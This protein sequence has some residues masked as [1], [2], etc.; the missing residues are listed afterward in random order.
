MCIFSFQKGLATFIYK[1]IFLIGFLFGLLS[2]AAEV[3][4]ETELDKIIMAVAKVSDEKVQT[5]LLRGVIA[6]LKGVSDIPPPKGWSELSSKLLK[7]KNSEL[8]E[9]TQT[10]N[11]FFGSADALKDALALILN[12]KA[13]FQKRQTTLKSLAAKNYS[14]L[15]PKL[16]VLLK[17]KLQKDAI[18]SYGFYRSSNIPK[19][20][21]RHYKKFDTQSRQAVIETLATR[22]EFASEIVS[23]LKAKKISKKE[24]PAYIARNL[25]SLLGQKFISVYGEVQKVSNDKS[26]LIAS[27]KKKLNSKAFN[28]ASAARGRL[29]YDKQCAICHKMYNTGGIIGPDL[30]GSNRADQDYILLNIIDPNF[31]VPEAYQMTTITKKDG[32]IFSGN[33]VSESP[34]TIELK[35]VGLKTTIAKSDIKSRKSSK[36]S[37]MPEGLLTNLNDREFFD[38]IKYLQ[39]NQQVE[40]AK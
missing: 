1:P 21:M 30:T 4:A 15:L 6:G 13:D 7:S 40:A 20:L 36:V 35:M 31:D 26:A 3:Q 38:L 37:M 18:R 34:S 27:Y 28:G 16:E 14:K 32:Q 12:E 5:N 2:T 25:E 23:A 39:T 10:L 29:V 33:I 24:I 11:Q 8:L 19:T 17:T 22:K 9:T